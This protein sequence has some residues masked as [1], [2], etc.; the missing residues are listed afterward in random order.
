MDDFFKE[1]IEQAMNE[2]KTI[3]FSVSGGEWSAVL[4]E[5]IEVLSKEELEEYHSE[6]EDRLDD[7]DDT[8]PEDLS[9]EEF[10]LWADAHENLKCLINEIDD[11]ISELS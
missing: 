4:G 7:M 3:R 1:L 10:G 8:K 2:G 9:S 5:D 6:L 11:R